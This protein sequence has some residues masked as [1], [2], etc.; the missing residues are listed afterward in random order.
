MAKKPMCDS[1]GVSMSSVGLVV[2]TYLYTF[3]Q[4][5]LGNHKK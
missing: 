3:F 2:G 5:S 1:K 4:S